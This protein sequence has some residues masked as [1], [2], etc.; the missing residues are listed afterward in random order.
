M[1]TKGPGLAPRPP[2]RLR[3]E[4]CG[5]CLA[6]ATQTLGRMLL[7]QARSTAKCPPQPHGP[8]RHTP[9]LAKGQLARSSTGHH[10]SS[11]Y[12]YLSRYTF[13]ICIFLQHSSSFLIYLF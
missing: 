9:P 5:S 1:E 10:E 7:T 8:D 2:P 13:I 6:R 4:D 3:L 11:L 12:I